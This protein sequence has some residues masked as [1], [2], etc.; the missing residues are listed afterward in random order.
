MNICR[1]SPAWFLAAVLFSAGPRA[2]TATAQ[3]LPDE[4]RVAPSTWL[5]RDCDQGESAQLQSTLKKYAAQLEGV[6]LDA[7]NNGPDDKLLDAVAAAASR[8][9]QYR[10]EAL[11]TGAGLG[12]S[13]EDLQRAREITRDQ[14][15][16][17][18]KSDFILRYKSQAVSALGIVAQTKGRAALQALARDTK[19][20]LS[21]SAQQALQPPSQ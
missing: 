20:P 14:Y 19:S 3:V 17:Q 16:Q 10:Q 11:R 12:L 1:Q 21:T 5:L 8:R 9:F 6:F 15:L 2:G 7:L 18:Q 13:A 4:A